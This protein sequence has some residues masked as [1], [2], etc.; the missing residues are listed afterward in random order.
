MRPVF[1]YLLF[2]LT[3]K[4]F[5]SQTEVFKEKEKYGIK[6]KGIVVVP[7][8]H[9]TVF[10]FDSTGKVC[11]VCTKT[12]T[13]HPN[14]FIKTPVLSWHCTY[15]NKKGSKL[16][17][18][19]ESGDST[20]VFTLQKASRQLF[21]GNSPYMTVAVKDKSMHDHRYMCTKDL[22]QLTFKA[23]EEIHFSPGE[24]FFVGKIRNENNSMYEGLLDR[25]EELILPFKYSHIKFNPIDSFIIGCT[26]GQGTNSEDDIYG[27]NGKKIASYHRHIEVA[28]KKFVVEKVFKPEE[29]LVI[30]N[31]ETKEE[32]KEHAEEVQYFSDDKVLMAN[33]GHWFTYELATGKKKAY[34]I[35]HKK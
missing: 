19:L 16:K 20:D 7:A 33:D 5:Y 13:A 23:Y 14:K 26:A 8:V 10:N 32:K 29:Y 6:E 28:T 2:C 21:E 35:K 9:D 3:W 30:L 17:I 4:S 24:L 12:R 34:D 25:K 27:Y 1:F 15:L 31:L 18:K 22:E 11:M